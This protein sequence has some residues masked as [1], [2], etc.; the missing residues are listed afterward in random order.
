MAKKPMETPEEEMTVTLMLDDGR[1]EECMVL[2]ILEVE[3]EAG[4]PR[5]YIALMPM[6][7][8]DADE[9]DVY[10]YRYLEES[11]REPALDNIESDDEYEA[12]RDAFDEWLDEQEYDELVAEDEEE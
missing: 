5:D 9:G 11:G 2:T 8:A 4:H 3:A 12:V 7:D 1:E 10:L 6:A